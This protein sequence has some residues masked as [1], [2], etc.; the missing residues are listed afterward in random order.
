MGKEDAGIYDLIIKDNSAKLGG[1]IAA[2][3]TVPGNGKDH[4]DDG[5]L[6]PC[7]TDRTSFGYL[8]VDWVNIVENQADIAGGGVAVVDASG[9]GAICDGFQIELAR[10][11][12]LP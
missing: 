8:T 3:G 10:S 6:S 7:P 2:Q 11:T 4:Y 1:G 5:T 12:G 9:T